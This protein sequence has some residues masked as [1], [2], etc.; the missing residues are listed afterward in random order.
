MLV[1]EPVS[2][3][4]VRHYP[5]LDLLEA[6]FEGPTSIETCA[7]VLLEVWESGGLLQTDC[8]A[9]QGRPVRLS[10]SSATVRGRVS[11]CIKD[12]YGYL[13]EFTVESAEGWFPG[14]Y[15]PACLL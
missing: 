10:V 4:S 7:A 5:C 14:A 1:A 6:A 8:D 11:S 12:E 3:R 9:A 13:V 15:L 2:A